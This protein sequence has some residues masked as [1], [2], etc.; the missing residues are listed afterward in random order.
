VG[1]GVPSQ[2]SAWIAACRLNQQLK[3]QSLAPIT[4]AEIERESYYLMTS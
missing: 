1:G 4:I 2:R 3:A